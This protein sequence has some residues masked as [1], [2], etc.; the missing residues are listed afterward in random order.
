METL[1]SSIL[2]SYAAKYLTNF[3]PSD[4][5]LSLWGMLGLTRQRPNAC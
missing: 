2:A 5:R 3:R 4:L 1:V